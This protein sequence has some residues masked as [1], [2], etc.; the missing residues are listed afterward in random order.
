MQGG[1]RRK[2]RKEQ[3]Y[4]M[5][6]SNSYTCTTEKKDG[7]NHDYEAAGHSDQECL[8]ALYQGAHKYLQVQYHE[9]ERIG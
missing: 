9:G 2:G 7:E 8:C 1:E 3:K 6:K 4:S 5:I